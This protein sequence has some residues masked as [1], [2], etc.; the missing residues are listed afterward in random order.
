MTNNNKIIKRSVTI[1]GH[2]TS[3][4]LEKPFWEALKDIAQARNISVTK[5]VTEIDKNNP[6]NLSSALRCY[7]LNYFRL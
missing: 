1:A 7:V 4:S 5:I 6:D 2:A 3:V